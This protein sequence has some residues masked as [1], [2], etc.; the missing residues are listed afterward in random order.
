VAGRQGE[1]AEDVGT[2]VISNYLEACSFQ[3]DFAGPVQIRA[4]DQ[5]TDFFG[6]ETHFRWCQRIW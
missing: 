3:H 1:H 4:L 2:A 6:V 5:Q